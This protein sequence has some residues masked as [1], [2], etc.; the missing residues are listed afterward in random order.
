MAN[1]RQIALGVSGS[2]VATQGPPNF[3][4]LPFPVTNIKVSNSLPGDLYNNTSTAE[5]YILVQGP[6][7]AT[8][9]QI[10]LGGGTGIET[11]TIPGPTVI[12]PVSGNITFSEGSNVTITGS[13]STITFAASGGGGGGLTWQSIGASQT[14][15]DNNGY[16]CTSGGT[17]SLA[18]P[19]ISSVG[20][21]VQ[22]I[23]DGSTAFQITQ[24]VGQQIRIGD[25][26]TTIGASG[27]LTSTAEGDAV[28]LICEI[29][30][31]KWVAYPSQGN[32]TVA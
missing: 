25:V 22:V 15:A 10:T 6:G 2:G 30:N 24:A 14:L 32:I 8:W 1:N 26:Q 4:A 29:A 11:V 23:L 12:T 17:L 19:P 21:T 7:G 20:D 13:G 27:S 16:F 28:T 5:V 31:T 3:S 9:Q 18:L